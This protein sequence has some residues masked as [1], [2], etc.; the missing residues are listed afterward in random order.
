MT[1]LP[2]IGGPPSPA[3]PEI[4][5][6]GLGVAPGI[7]IGPAHPME[8]RLGTV[9]EYAI[10]PQAVA[11]ECARL[12]EAVAKA[13]RQ[14]Q[15]LKAKARLL[16]EHAAEEVALLL[17]AH[18]AM[19]SGSRLLRGA[20]ARI[21]ERLINAEA[22]VQAEIAAI[23]AQFAGM[24]DAYLSARVDDIR[25]VGARLMRN[26]VR[27]PYQAFSQ[28]PSGSVVLAAEVTPADTALMDPA[29]IAGLAAE[30]G[31][32]H[33]H[34][35]VMARSLG[36]PAV[37]GVPGLMAAARPTAIAIIDGDRGMVIVDPSAATQAAYAERQAEAGRERHRLRVL[38]DKPSR[39]RDGTAVTLTAN[40]ERSRD[41]AVACDVG[42][43]GVGLLR[44]EFLFMNRP[45][46]PDEEEQY[47]ALRDIVEGMGDRPVTIRTLDIG[48]DKLA[49][50][51]GRHFAAAQNPSLG[52]R[53]IR[54]S[55]VEPKLLE[56]QLAA[57]LRAAAHGRVRILVPMVTTVAE[58][59]SV[60]DIVG[61]VARRLRRRRVPLPEA[62]PPI[63][64]MIEIPGAALIADALAREADFFA[65]GTNDL[66]M[67]TLAAD[68]SDEAVAHLYDPLHA[69]V[70]RLLQ[71]TIEAALRARI[72]VSV[73][74]E[75]A[76]DPRYTAL[77]VGMG[78][79]ELSMTPSRLLEVKRRLL[80]IDAVAAE[81][82][83]R[84]ILEQSDHGRIAALLDDFN[85][86][87]DGSILC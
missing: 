14:I 57:V 40:L 52:L 24:D 42:A 83:A 39:T 3:R 66:V 22:A 41:T 2:Q 48:G 74:G 5:L 78:V 80:A 16:P 45:D 56:A 31:G 68:R 28:L 69:G 13:R 9:P 77:L 79:R 33:G 44:S 18:A 64:V 46:L 63:G 59:R 70:L 29:R 6:Y 36:L 73:C 55:L 11:A 60:R 23:A 49:P 32:T 43:A 8:A 84:L 27:V 53:A 7:A 82:R 19:L 15:K 75:I 35:A 72:P 47:R 25:E 65:I 81:R 62:L 87:D 38:R 10:E 12:A 61:R 34:T 1:I 67:Y 76:G 4:V 86:G 37:L 17:D 71:N 50:S 21:R 54:L 85:A 51:L 26:L 30:I 58:L 20:E